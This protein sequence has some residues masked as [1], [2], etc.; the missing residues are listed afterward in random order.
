MA[1][2]G[3]LRISYFAK[4]PTKNNRT[5]KHPNRAVR[6]AYTFLQKG[7][8]PSFA[9][10]K[11][12]LCVQEWKPIIISF[13]HHLLVDISW[14]FPL[15]NLQILDGFHVLILQSTRFQTSIP[16]NYSFHLLSIFKYLTKYITYVDHPLCLVY[17]YGFT[18]MEGILSMIVLLLPE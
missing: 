12:I 1:L 16:K 9:P 10:K 11:A 13:I 7:N 5:F 4:K 17:I 15:E 6:W 18:S 8:G 14:I 2:E 3:L